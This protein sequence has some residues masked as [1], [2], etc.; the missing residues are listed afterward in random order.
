MG[1]RD[2]PRIA[3]VAPPSCWRFAIV[4]V[5]RS[6]IGPAI[7]DTM[8][9]GMIGVAQLETHREKTRRVTPSALGRSPARS[10][11][12]ER[13]VSEGRDAICVAHAVPETRSLAD[14]LKEFAVE[15]TANRSERFQMRANKIGAQFPLRASRRGYEDRSHR[16]SANRA[17]ELDR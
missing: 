10:Q 7:H 6:R 13:Q 17:I 3:A 5:E 4:L 1:P 11:H 8:L 14:V 16:A 9:Q 2:A 15:L 12:L